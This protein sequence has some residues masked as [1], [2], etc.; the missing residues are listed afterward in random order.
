MSATGSRPRDKAQ[1]WLAGCEGF[2]IDSPSRRLGSVEEIRQDPELRR[3]AALVV[4]AGTLRTHRLVIPVD[5]IAG[6]VLGERTIFVEQSA[7]LAA[8]SA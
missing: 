1:D 7:S 4:R 3:P 6:I 5:G 8:N 2:R